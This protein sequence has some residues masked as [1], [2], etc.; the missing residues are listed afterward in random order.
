MKPQVKEDFNILKKAFTFAP[1]LKHPDPSLTYI[2][3][4][5]ASYLS[6]YKPDFASKSNDV[7]IM[8]TLGKILH[9]VKQLGY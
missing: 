8:E 6:F 2:V 7:M 1:I 4:T 9:L 3:Q 5:N